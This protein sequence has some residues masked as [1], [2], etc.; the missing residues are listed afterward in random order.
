MK[1]LPYLIFWGLVF[2]FQPLFAG[3]PAASQTVTDA[4]NRTVTLARPLERVV[5]INS[6]SA[7][8]L[9]ALGVDLEQKAVGVTTYIKDNPEFWPRLKDKPGIEFTS[10]SYETLARLNP[11]L[12]V[13]Y[14]NSYRY[15]DQAKLDAL[16]IPAIYL[17]CY[18]PRTLDRDIRILA[19]LFDKDEEGETLI[20]WCRSREQMITRRLSGIPPDQR[21][22]VFSY[23]YPDANLD[24]GIYRTCNRTRSD[25]SL[26]EKAGAVNIGAGLP[27]PHNVVSPEWI[28]ARNPDA[29][30]ASVIGR[31]YSGYSA[32]PAAAL[33]N[34]K[35]MQTRLLSDRTFQT[36][37]A[38]KEKRILVFSQDLKQ[39][40]AYVIG[41][42][43]VAKFLYPDRFKDFDPSDLARE[44]YGRWCGLPFRGVFR[45]PLDPPVTSVSIEDSSGRTLTLQVPVNRVA[46]L[47]TSACRELCLLGVEDRVVGITEYILRFPQLY[48]KL[49][50]K[51]VIGSVYQP[52]YETILARQPDLLVMSTAPENLNPVVQ[53]LPPLGVPVAALDLQPNLGDT[54]AQ[55]E[56]HYNGELLRLARVM[57]RTDRAAAFIRWKE[58]IF[59]LIRNRTRHLSRPRVIGIGCHSLS[60]DP[61]LTYTIW[62]GRRIIPLAHGEDLAAEVAGT[63]VSRE[64]VLARDPDVLLLASYSQDGYLGYEVGDTK[65][66]ARR[67]AE[68]KKDPVLSRTR[69][70]QNDKVF[71]FDYYGTG[72][73]GQTPLAALYLAKRLYPEQFKDIDPRQIHREYCERFF[74]IPFQGVWFYP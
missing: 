46:C 23:V 24:R 44:F 57:G 26:L 39:G 66:I 11:Q 4:L 63:E 10:P 27:E 31:D 61:A 48:P 30:I 41:L 7:V 53:K 28:M 33:Q 37:T 73:G 50:G 56:A 69:A 18:D 15:T 16:G 29:V 8:I 72:S 74:H 55:R 70:V 52:S 22:R 38:A 20:A 67:M 5:L 68:L 45:Y 32:D 40:P 47:H 36:T 6:G 51:P 2:S 49:S 25:H 62:A 43:H 64:W 17:D 21:P 3:T 58:G 59:S 54:P 12:I 42:A 35:A 14:G 71:I 65:R 19:R 9:R 1:A 13:F 34:L 60:R